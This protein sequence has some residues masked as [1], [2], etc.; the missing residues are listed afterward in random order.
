MANIGKTAQ[1]VMDLYFQNFRK[2]E[3]FFTDVHFRYLC[4]VA[5][6]KIVEDEYKQ[7]RKEALAQL[8]FTEV[9]LSSEWLINEEIK[10]EKVPDV[11]NTWSAKLKHPIFIFPYDPAGNGI[12]TIR[13]LNYSAC[14]EFIRE[15]A[16]RKWALCNMPVTKN[17]YWYIEGKEIFFVNAKCPLDSAKLQVSYISDP[18]DD[19]F[20]DEGGVIPQSKEELII[21]STLDILI[22]A[23][24]GVVVDMTNNANPN[25]VKQTEID[26]VLQDDIRNKPIG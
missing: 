7:A 4:G 24:S 15:S 5:Y 6:S 23:R 14:N 20:G 18:S 17:V 2:S 25:K 11:K 26:T 21:R 16:R 9:A 8:G 3:D 12:Q 10:V 19:S 1:I 13:N 22:K